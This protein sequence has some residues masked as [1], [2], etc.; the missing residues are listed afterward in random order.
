LPALGLGDAT[1]LVTQR[2]YDIPEDVEP[3]QQ[4]RP[5]EDDADLV[6]WFDDRGAID[7][8]TPRGWREQ[9]SG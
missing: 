7:F 1:I 3:R 6:A 5:L 2:E 8:N 4:D 9:P